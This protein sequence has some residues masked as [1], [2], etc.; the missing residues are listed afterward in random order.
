MHLL[1][2]GANSDVALALARKFAEAEKAHITLASRNQDLLRKKAQ[3]L[4][5]R[6]QVPAIPRFFDADDCKSHAGFYQSLDPKPDG[7]ILAFGYLGDQQK[8]QQDFEEAA[9]MVKTNFLDAVSI[10]EVIAADFQRRG[11]GFIIGISSVAGERGR[12]SNAI[13]GAS[14]AGLT[15]YLSGLRNRLHRHNVRVMTVL[16][17]FVRTKMTEHLDLPERLLAE[18]A[19]AAEDIYGAYRKK[20]DVVYTK[21]FWKWIM[22]II[23]LIP[24]PLFKRLKL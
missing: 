11:H 18:P 13:Y 12:Q 2:L 14:K 19:E 15:A 16:P 17:G 1:I 6:Y 23:R 9:K 3:D 7:V 24:E 21:W 22:H 8:A 10:L 5:I 4:A 20:R